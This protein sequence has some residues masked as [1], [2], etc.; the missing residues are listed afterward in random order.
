MIRLH[1]GLSQL[2]V[3]IFVIIGHIGKIEIFANK[4]FWS[5]NDFRLV[6]ELNIGW[7][8]HQ[9]HH[10]SEDYNLSTA[11]RQSIMQTWYTTIPCLGAAFIGVHPSM[12]YTHYRYAAYAINDSQHI[13]ASIWHG[14]FG[15]TQSQFGIWVP[16]WSFF[17]ILRHIIE[18]IMAEILFVLI[19]IMQDQDESI[20][21]SIL[22]WFS[23]MLHEPLSI[24]YVMLK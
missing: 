20:V 4:N 16:L 13:L 23:C 15:F 24:N 19:K 3:L 9:V 10:S 17:S 14:S 18:Y 12:F 1:T 21:S 7:S 2:L 8:S 11:L 22:N 5:L 6:H